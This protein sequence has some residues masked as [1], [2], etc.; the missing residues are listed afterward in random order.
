MTSKDG[1]SCI[2]VAAQDGYD[3]CV[4][5]LVAVGADVNLTIEP[6]W[7]GPNDREDDGVHVIATASQKN[8]HRCLRLIMPHVDLDV[9]ARSQVNRSMIFC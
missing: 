1:G 9:V 7:A 2:Y 8:F 3:K 5:L 6:V 4:A